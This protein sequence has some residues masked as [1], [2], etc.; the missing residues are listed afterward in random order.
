MTG[1]HPSEILVPL[2]G[3]EASVRAVPVAGRIAKR[4]GLGLRLF[5]ASSDGDAD[6]E[7][8]LQTVADQHL[9]NTDVALEVAVADDPVAAIIAAAGETAMVCMATAAS[10]LPHQGHVGSVAEGVTRAMGRPVMLVGPQMEPSP[11]T[12]TSRVIVPVDGSAL[13]EA[14]LPVAADLA[15]AFN[16]PLWLVTVMVQQK[17]GAANKGS[18][19]VTVGVG[20]LRQ[21]SR[22]LRK[23]HDIDAQYDILHRPDTAEAIVDF[24]GD[25]GTVVMTTH[26]RAGLSRVFGGSVATGVVAHSQRAVVLLHPAD[27]E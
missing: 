10:L 2:D 14:I 1:T 26:G 24:A 22:E 3:R 18:G 11:G 9:Q 27:V 16:E 8:W 20:Y 17:G 4:L 15:R 6:L 23:S 19:A 13:S 25:D 12:L 21:L 7:S 5:A